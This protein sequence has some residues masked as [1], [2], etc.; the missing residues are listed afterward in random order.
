MVAVPALAQFEVKLTVTA[1]VYSALELL[2]STTLA[3]I[4]VLPP[5]DKVPFTCTPRIASWKL[6]SLPLP[7]STL[8]APA[9]APPPLLPEP[10]LLFR[11]LPQA[12]SAA[13]SAAPV[14]PLIKKRIWFLMVMSLR[15]SPAP[16]WPTAVAAVWSTILGVTNIKSSSLLFCVWVLRNSQPRSGRSPR[17]GTLVVVTFWV[18]S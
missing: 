15:G 3:V 13:R 5:A 1:C 12:A 17:N 11:P 2:A 6:A 16:Y 4:W 8:A 14:I 10:L 7:S 18:V 9:V